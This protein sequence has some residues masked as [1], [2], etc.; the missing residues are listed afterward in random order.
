MNTFMNGL[1]NAT[2]FTYTDNGA[3]AHKSTGSKLFDL[4]ALGGAYRQRSNADCI[5]LFMNAFHENE[6]YAM[7]CLFYLRDARGGQGERRFYRVCMGYLAQKHPEAVRRN[8]QYIPEFGRWDDLF[9]LIGTPVEEDMW[10]FLKK[11]IVEGIEVL[12]KIK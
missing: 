7:K 9:C 2:N 1:K 10:V 4:F 6:E 12:K 3:L 5:N 8:L 11:S